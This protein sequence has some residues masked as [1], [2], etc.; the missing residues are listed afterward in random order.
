MAHRNG[1]KKVKTEQKEQKE[2]EEQKEQNK[3]CRAEEFMRLF[4][5][6]LQ[7]HHHIEPGE[8]LEQGFIREHLEGRHIPIPISVFSNKRLSALEAIVKYLRENEGLRNADV[9]RILHKK[10]ATV[11]LTYRNAAAKA[12]EKLHITKS[13]IFIPTDAIS[14]SG[15]SVLE[16]VSMHLHETYGISYRRIGSLLGRDER[17]IW[18]VCSRAR[19][20]Q[21]VEAK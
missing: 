1:S 12:G 6:H 11:W 5:N 14:S 2:Q 9:A 15:L 7:E 13:D 16:S 17:T 8:Y 4:R 10:P 21:G 18:T 20:K 19:K 3:S